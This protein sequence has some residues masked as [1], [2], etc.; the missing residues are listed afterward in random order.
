MIHP[1]VMGAYLALFFL[2]ACS[3]F[4]QA[5][6]ST[7]LGTVSDISGAS[8]ANAKV[9]ATETNTGIVRN[10]ATNESG[11]YTFPDI[12]SGTYSV[13]VELTGFKRETRNSVVLQVNTSTR[14]DFTLQPGAVSESVEVTAGTPQ[15]QTDRADVETKID[16]VQ[17]AKFTNGHESQFPEPAQSG[18]GNHAR[19]LPALAIL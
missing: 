17:T 16:T 4:G 18:S 11:N 6:N 8:A 10:S 12:P 14:V 19:H 15:L 2:A 3:S 5:V 1:R 9:T 7:L 13:T